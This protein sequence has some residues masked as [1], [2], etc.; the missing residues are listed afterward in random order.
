LSVVNSKASLNIRRPLALPVAVSLLCGIGLSACAGDQKTVSW[1]ED[2]PS[3]TSTIRDE[4]GKLVQLTERDHQQSVAIAE[5]RKQ[6]A[7]L[8]SNS[9]QIALQQAQIQAMSA[10]LEKVQNRKFRKPVLVKKPR[11]AEKKRVSPIAAPVL[12]AA[13]V[14][15]VVDK[16]AQVEAEKNA[17]TASYL[18]LKSGR[19]DEASKGF[20]SQLELYADGEYAD[21]AWYWLGETQLAQN[22]RKKA[23]LSFNYVVEH[24]SNSV[25]HAASL[26]KLAQIAVDAH[27]PEQAKKYFKKIINEHADS[28]LAEQARTA[29]RQLQ[30]ASATESGK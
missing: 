19:Y 14:V 16:A 29:L 1:G 6:V 23:T 10:Q 20:H 7:E 15:P 11:P 22:D 26:F 9:E 30:Q 13:P 3:I 21:Q 18:A 24:Y 17:Y 25:K 27:Q 2:K 5:L 8:I 12:P 28:S 4:Q